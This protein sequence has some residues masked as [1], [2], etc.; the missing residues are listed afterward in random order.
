MSK[1]LVIGNCNMNGPDYASDFFKAIEDAGYIL[2]YNSMS[3][4]SCVIMME[5]P[6]EEENEP[7]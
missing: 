1:L 4:T 6:E 5:I 7:K 2:G 3:K